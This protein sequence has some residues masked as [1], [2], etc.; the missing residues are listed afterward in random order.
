[1]TTHEPLPVLYAPVL[2]LFALGILLALIVLAPVAI[3]TGR[4]S[5]GSW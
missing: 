2:L 4:F 1:V 3:L 5:R